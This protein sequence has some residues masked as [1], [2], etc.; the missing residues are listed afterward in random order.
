[1]IRLEWYLLHPIAVHFPIALLTLGL[2]VAVWEARFKRPEWLPEAVTWLLWLGT[3]S[4]WATFGLGLLAEKTVPHVPMAWETMA[5]HETLGYWTVGL[6]TTLSAGRYW[7][8]RREYRVGKGVALSFLAGWLAASGILM[9]TGL[10]GGRLV[11]DYGVGSASHDGAD[12]DSEYEEEP[13]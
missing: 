1:M 4:A 12:D 8:R 2:A 6:F 11:F 5:D 7:M 9:R 3:A 10:L 13:E